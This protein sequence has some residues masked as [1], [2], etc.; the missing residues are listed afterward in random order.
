MTASSFTLMFKWK[1][2]VAQCWRNYT[3]NLIIYYKM[4]VAGSLFFAYFLSIVQIT[5]LKKRV[6]QESE[7]VWLKGEDEVN[8]VISKI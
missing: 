2:N 7:T 3:K 1:P 4:G 8:V 5:N 6:R